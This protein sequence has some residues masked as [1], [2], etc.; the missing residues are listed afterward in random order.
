[1]SENVS[2]IFKAASH[3]GMYET[4]E[5]EAKT[6]RCLPYFEAFGCLEWLT[7]PDQHLDNLILF[8]Q[9]SNLF[10]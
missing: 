7:I 3:K 4:L 6:E 10:I 8:L 1:M 9:Q 5:W 2:F